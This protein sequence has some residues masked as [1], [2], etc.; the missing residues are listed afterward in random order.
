MSFEFGNSGANPLFSPTMDYDESLFWNGARWV[1]LKIQNR[2]DNIPHFGNFI[3]KAN[4]TTRADRSTQPTAIRTVFRNTGEAIDIEFDTNG[5]LLEKV[6]MGGWPLIVGREYDFLADYQGVRLRP[7][8]LAELSS[9]AANHTIFV[10]FSN[11]AVIEITITPAMLTAVETIVS[12]VPRVGATLSAYTIFNMIPSPMPTLVTNWEKSYGNSNIWEAVSSAPTI[13][14]TE[15]DIGY[16]FRVRVNGNGLTAS[17][18]QV[19]SLPSRIVRREVTSIY[20]V[21]TLPNELHIGQ[22]LQ[23]KLEDNHGDV[24][25][26]IEDLR[27]SA[28]HGKFDNYNR[29]VASRG[30]PNDTQVTVTIALC[31]CAVVG[32]DTCTCDSIYDVFITTIYA[33]P[34]NAAWLQDI[35]S[36]AGDYDWHITAP[37]V[38]FTMPAGFDRA[39]VNGV[40]INGTEEFFPTE[41]GS[42]ELWFENSATGVQT[43]GHTL[44]LK[45]CIISPSMRAVYSTERLVRTSPVRVYLTV[46]ASGIRSV[47]LDG[48][49]IEVQSDYGLYFVVVDVR[50]DRTLQFVLTDEAGRAEELDVRIDNIFTFS[51][52]GRFIRENW[53]WFLIGLL[54]VVIIIVVISSVVG[55]KRSKKRIE[56]KKKQM[57]AEKLQQ[58]N[59]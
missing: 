54:L 39:V 23:F 6:T 3:I 20:L 2:T 30:I 4:L 32:R 29:F 13:T 15:G 46:G 34:F 31:E 55:A 24:L 18:V 35:S 48:T 56:K 47:T 38:R 8:F 45:V 53:L 26:N 37:R 40:V 59:E 42:F 57:R 1:C 36:P 16:R 44:D 11:G 28:T 14:L 41:S 58:F 10:H 5:N 19:K 22:S 9:A 25:C 33:T 7:V 21:G 27:F 12:G 49:A 52:L 50:H 43:E 51:K 17:V